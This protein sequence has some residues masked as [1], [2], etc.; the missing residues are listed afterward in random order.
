MKSRKVVLGA[1]AGA[2]G[3]VAA[4]ATAKLIRDH[5]F[6]HDDGAHL[7]LGSLRSDPITVVADDGVPLYAEI[8]EPRDAA[9]QQQD[10]PLPTLVFVHGYALNLDVWHFQRAA[11]RGKMR[12]IYYDQRS[13]GRSGH[14]PADH[15]TIDQLGR[16]LGRVLED[17]TGDEP[18]IVVGHSMGGMTLL[19]LA[20]QRPELFGTK[21]VGAALISTTAGGLDTGR[22]L[23]PLLPAGIGPGL[24]TRI[25]DVLSR[26][27][28]VVD[29]MRGYGKEVAMF[30]TDLYSFGTDVPRSYVD[31]VHH[32]HDSTP[33][34]VVADFFPAFASLDSWTYLEPFSRVPTAIICGTGDK[35]T[36]ITHSRKM[37]SKI[38][39]S[40]LLEVPDAGHLVIMESH[41][42]VGPELDSL[43]SRVADRLADSAGK[44]RKRARAR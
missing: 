22:I 30:F 24:I 26:G 28:S 4:G 10:G 42:Q 31:F 17:L 14:S 36:G 12:A 2:A 8:D 11:Y 44:P 23:F 16:D 39:G 32:M 13:H 40:D 29:R 6:A 21:I 7:A 19:S 9:T 43:I 25:V 1:A 27:S 34:S 18:V 38:A 41:E 20:E 5:R 3:V 15:D 35:I 37:H 33:F